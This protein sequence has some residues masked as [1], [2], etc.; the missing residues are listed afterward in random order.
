MPSMAI[1]SAMRRDSV[2]SSGRYLV[3]LV[4]RSAL[5]PAGAI[6]RYLN[7]DHAT[8]Y[9]SGTASRSCRWPWSN[10]GARIRRGF[11]AEFSGTDRTV[12]DYLPAEVLDRQPAAVRLL[13]RTSNLDRI[14]GEL[15]DLL[16]GDQ[17]PDRR[18]LPRVRRITQTW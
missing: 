15:A 18:G 6:S 2:R 8:Q 10:S 4:Y 12:A 14:N 3:P 5:I 16:T 17:G 9:S 13:L 7:S 11:A 1:C